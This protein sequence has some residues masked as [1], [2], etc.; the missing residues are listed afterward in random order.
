MDLKTFM[1]G[2]S[3]EVDGYRLNI[4]FFQYIFFCVHRKKETQIGFEKV[5]ESKRLQNFLGEL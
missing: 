3:M 1:M 2:D 4:Y 5:K